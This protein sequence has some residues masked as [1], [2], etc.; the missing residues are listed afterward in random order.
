MTPRGWAA[1]MDDAATQQP[2]H[3]G[4]D[5]VVV[6]LDVEGDLLPRPTG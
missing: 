4:W 3:V 1:P 5:R 6:I 2:L